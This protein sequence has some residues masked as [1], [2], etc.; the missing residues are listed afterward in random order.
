M[1][2][3]GFEGRFP[4]RNSQVAKALARTVRRLRREKG[5]SQDDLAERIGLEQASISHIENAR[6]NP[7]LATLEALADSLEISF[8]E[9]FEVRKD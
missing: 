1:S 2:R 8:V 4:A 9:L 7:T 3:S 5:W 6:A